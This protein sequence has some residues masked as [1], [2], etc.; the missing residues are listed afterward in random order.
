MKIFTYLLLTLLQFA[1]TQGLFSVVPATPPSTANGQT[2]ATPYRENISAKEFL[3][4]ANEEAAKEPK[5]ENSSFTKL[6]VKMLVTLGIT[7]IFVVIFAYFGRRFLST[8]GGATTRNGK[9][10]ILERRALSNKALLYIV[11]VEEKEFLL[12]ESHQG[13]H[14]IQELKEKP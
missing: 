12:A 11:Q 8:R 10:Q 3:K 13:V 6:F 2:K 7:L 4:E 14:L 9:I 5:V 1:P